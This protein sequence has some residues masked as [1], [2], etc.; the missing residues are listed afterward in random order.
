M[1][2]MG[3]RLADAGYFVLLPDL[4]YRSG[5]YEPMVPS[6]VFADPKLREG[7]MKFVTSL[8]RETKISDA[9]AFIDYLS[10]QPEVRGT[11]FGAT[12]YCL[13]GNCA[14]TAAG[15]YPDRFAAVASFH[16]GALVTDQPDSPHLFV[17]N[18]KGRVY[19]GGAVE[20][21]F[22]TDEQKA[23]LDRALTEASVDH[24]VETYE[25]ARHGWA[26][27]DLPVY[28]EA[29]AE[30]HWTSLLKLFTDAFASEE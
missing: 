4:Y 16:A 20:D 23:A 7:F 10:S 30:R 14:L 1:W 9:G 19:V 8:N 25:G 26:V 17:G 21:A 5:S 28:D 6:E 12:G 3:Q 24:V 2:E 13:G 27:P 15:A 22:F 18:I 11:R 29:A